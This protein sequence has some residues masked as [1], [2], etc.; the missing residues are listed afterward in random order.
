[1]KKIIFLMAV[2]A[3]TATAFI[4][5]NNNR[6]SSSEE[7]EHTDVVPSGTYMGVAERVDPGEREIYVKTSDGKTLELYFTDN[8]Q[9]LQ[10]DQPVEFSALAEGQNVEV[11]VEKMGERLEPMTVKIM[12]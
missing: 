12:E 6:N 3:A 2:I 5:C 11:T 9:L 7:I 10:N 4:A 8:T 1:M